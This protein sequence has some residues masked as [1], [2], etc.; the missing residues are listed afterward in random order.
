MR[1]YCQGFDGMAIW[2]LV[3]QRSGGLNCIFLLHYKFTLLKYDIN[4]KILE[5][6]V[7][8]PEN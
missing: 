2:E 4:S 3:Q 8:V 5:L 7:C 1:L 6:Q